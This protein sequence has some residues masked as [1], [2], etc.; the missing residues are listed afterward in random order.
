MFNFMTFYK[1]I[2]IFGLEHYDLEGEE[3]KVHWAEFLNRHSSKGI[4][5]SDQAVLL[6]KGPPYGK[7]ILT[8]G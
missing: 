7:I 8:K 1:R 4:C 6:P 3:K 5:M 2:G